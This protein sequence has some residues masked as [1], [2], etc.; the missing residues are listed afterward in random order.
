MSEKIALFPATLVN[1][2]TFIFLI[3]VSH[4]HTSPPHPR[5]MYHLSLPQLENSWKR[6][7]ISPNS[8]ILWRHSQTAGQRYEWPLIV[9]APPCA[10]HT[11]FSL[12]SHQP[13]SAVLA[14]HHSASVLAQS[15]F[16]RGWE[17][18]RPAWPFFPESTTVDIPKRGY[19]TDP[20]ACK[21]EPP[22][23]QAHTSPAGY[24]GRFTPKSCLVPSSEQGSI[25]SSRALS[26]TQTDLGLSVWVVTCLRLK[27]ELI[28]EY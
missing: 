20:Q 16:Y 18:C 24:G 4:T 15:D 22:Q 25:T 6:P 23:A 27:W 10:S 7:H 5:W 8:C 19:K 28:S 11:C 14:R 1:L 12:S 26:K 21:S 9:I 13:P 3:N 2:W 17:N